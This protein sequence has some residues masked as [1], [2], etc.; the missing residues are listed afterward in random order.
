VATAHLDCFSGIAGD[1]LLAALIDAGAPV[2]PL[3]A[4]L[5]RLKLPV[6]LG[7]EEV[8]HCGVRALH[9]E[10]EAPEDQPA[11]HLPEI[12]DII[13]ASELPPRARQRALDAFQVLGEAEAAIHNVPLEKVH[14]HEVGALDS[15]TDILGSAYALDLL[16]LDHLSAAPVP[17]GSGRVKCDHGWMP[18]PAPATA[19][20]M[21]GL[22][23]APNP[24]EGELT[25]P[26]GAAVLKAWVNQ[27]TSQPLL[28]YDRVGHGAGTRRYPTHPNLL[29]VFV[30]QGSAS[31][32]LETD[33]VWQLETT[34]DDQPGE[35]IAHAASQALLAG[36]L[37][38]YTIATHMKKGRPGCLLVVLA[39][40]GKEAAIAALVLAETR[41]LGLRRTRVARW[42]LP[43]QAGECVTPWG[44]VR[45][46]WAKLQGLKGALEWQPSPEFDDCQS[47]AR[48]H[49]V[50]LVEVTRVA[51]E[52]A[53]AAGLP[54]H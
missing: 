17:L 25:T 11:R 6:T 21:R 45:V 52:S 9:L 41:S 14:F 36:A 31:T 27:W 24:V 40:E 49:Q 29:R 33:W 22:P 51:T 2:D 1:M 34:I 13:V 38:A 46:K 4:M 44:T 35:V 5:D 16:D 54:V 37:D 50:P 53:W 26:T 47:I 48:S 10:I 32:G 15:I 28:T 3:R 20:L 42:K 18:V 12:Q 23:L 8:S 43:R 19:L 7:V 39:P 30:G